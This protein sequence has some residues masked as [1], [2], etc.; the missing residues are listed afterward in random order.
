MVP[1][2][3]CQN[4]PRF[5]RG[6]GEGDLPDGWNWESSLLEDICDREARDCC[7]LRRL[8]FEPGKATVRAKD[9]RRR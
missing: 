9:A 4:Q 6:R 5:R 1:A 2:K 3:S 8:K 7:G